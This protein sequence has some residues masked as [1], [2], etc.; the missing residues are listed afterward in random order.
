VAANEA[1]RP[2]RTRDE[3]DKNC[4]IQAQARH[5]VHPVNPVSR[6]RNGDGSIEL[7]SWFSSCSLRL[8]APARSPKG[9]SFGLLTPAAMTRRIGELAAQFRGAAGCRLAISAQD[10]PRDAERGEAGT[11]RFRRFK[12]TRRRHFSAAQITMKTIILTV[13]FISVLLAASLAQADTSKLS[14]PVSALTSENMTP[15]R[16]APFLVR[17]DMPSTSSNQESALNSPAANWK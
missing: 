8:R 12:N 5:R 6:S 3:L 2:I 9:I 1:I 13:P 7:K 17:S 15:I 14:T 10:P 11:I 16:M 4:R